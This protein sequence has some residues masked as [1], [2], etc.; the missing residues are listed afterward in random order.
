MTK[1][2]NEKCRKDPMDSMDAVCVNQDGDFACC[3]ECELEYKKQMNEF[4]DNFG[5]DNWYN[6]W[7]GKIN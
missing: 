7:M 1:C 4:F 3:H 6:D 5:D 2:V